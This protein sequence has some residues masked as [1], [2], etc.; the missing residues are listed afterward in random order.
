MVAACQVRTVSDCVYVCVCVCVCCWWWCRIL[1][2]VCWRS[3]IHYHTPRLTPTFTSVRCRGLHQPLTRRH[4]NIFS[5][6]RFCDLISRWV[7]CCIINHA[8][9]VGRRRSAFE[10]VCLSA[11]SLQNEWSQSVQTW[12]RE[13][14]WAVLEVTWFWDWKVKGQGHRVSNNTQWH[15][16]SNYNRVSFTYEN[17]TACRVRTLWLHSRFCCFLVFWVFR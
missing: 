7:L 15:F 9:Y 2:L 10:T 11:A 13:W 17:N 12:C 1:H 8:D 14:F 4:R 16:I 3:L 5:T 6:D